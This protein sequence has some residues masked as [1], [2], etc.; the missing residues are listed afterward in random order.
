MLFKEIT[1]VVDHTLLRVDSTWDQIKET[2]DEAIEYQAASV[3]IP[4][5]YAAEAV[6]YVEGKIPVCVVVG[7]PNGYSTTA[8]KVAETREAI[9]NGVSEVD[10]VINIGFLKSGRYDAVADEIKA[11]KEA[12]GNKILKVIVEACLLTEEEKIRMCQ[13]ITE[14]GADYIKTSTGFSTG[15]ATTEDVA[16]FAKHIGP[17]VKIKAAGGIRSLEDAR[18]L[19]DSGASRLGSS[20]IIGLLKNN[21]AAGY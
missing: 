14:A 1:S 21:E 16:L 10:M 9:A 17:D 19:M 13:I 15:N 3:C 12:C 4:P 18:K 11:I 2:C 7:F 5:A 20:S 8:A 6:K